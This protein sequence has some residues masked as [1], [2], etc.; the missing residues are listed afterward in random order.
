MNRRAALLALALTACGPMV[1]R[2]SP[3]LNAPAAAGGTQAVT[4][5][6]KRPRFMSRVGPTA[7]WVEVPAA[8]LD[9]TLTLIQPPHTYGQTSFDPATNTGQTL[10]RLGENT[11]IAALSSRAVKSIAS[12][13]TQHQLIADGAATVTVG[14]NTKALEVAIRPLI[15][16]VTLEA[17]P[18]SPKPGDTISV[19][20][21]VFTPAYRV[22]VDAEMV[23]DA[24]VPGGSFAAQVV[25]HD[26]EAVRVRV[27]ETAKPGETFTVAVAVRNTEFPQTTNALAPGY[28]QGE[29]EL[30]VS[31][32]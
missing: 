30:T 28:A 17:P 10:A 2:E 9:G 31:S 32:N 18:T 5:T 1:A 27:L 7:P 4:V 8:D 24:A 16:R 3:R 25:G 29:L 13:H 12:N 11:V 23:V 15:S 22:L 6:V 19:P 26:A 21:F 14:V 20:F